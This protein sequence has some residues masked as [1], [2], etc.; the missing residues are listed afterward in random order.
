MAWWKTDSATARPAGAGEPGPD[1]G[2]RTAV[3]SD[4]LVRLVRLLARRAV[5]EREWPGAATTVSLVP[6]LDDMAER[7]VRRY[8]LRCGAVGAITGAVSLPALGLALPAN[9]LSSL[10]LQVRMIL[11]IAG[12]YGH[13]PETRDFETDVLLLM[14]GDAAK[15]A[16]K[17]V[18]LELSQEL[19]WRVIDRQLAA[20][21][22]RRLEPLLAGRIL[23]VTSSRSAEALAK[24][25]PLVGAPVGFGID[26]AYA[27]M[28]GSRAVA[29]YRRSSSEI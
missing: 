3:G 13:T 17:R 21:A 22:A 24:L 25:V 10:T 29:Y 7:V 14:A 2:A 20:A 23:V 26:W 9:V 4:A 16:V 28:V 27:R 1:G 11:Q 8:A 19:T 18:G 6:V 15:E 5:A 12:I